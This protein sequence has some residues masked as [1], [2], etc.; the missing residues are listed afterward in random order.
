MNLAAVILTAFTAGTGC[1]RSL[2]NLLIALQCAELAIFLGAAVVLSGFCV[3]GFVAGSSEAELDSTLERFRFRGIAASPGRSLCPRTVT[4]A[5]GALS[6]D[7]NDRRLRL[8]F[9]YT[10]IGSS[11]RHR[12]PPASVDLYA[13]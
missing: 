1:S 5:V 12:V 8:R 2:H 3:G 7:D 6:R 9:G 10:A 11:K 13:A 4:P